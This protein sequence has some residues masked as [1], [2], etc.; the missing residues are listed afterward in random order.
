MSFLF[1]L[2]R[3]LKKTMFGI[4]LLALAIQMPVFSDNYDENEEKQPFPRGYRGI[5]LRMGLNDVRQRLLNDPWFDYRGESELSMR[6]RPN[7]SFIDAGG[8]LFISRGLFQFEATEIEEEAV[9]NPDDQNDTL[10]LSPVSSIQYQLS[11]IVLELNPRTIDWYTVY[12]TL[13]KRYGEPR[14]LNPQRVWWQDARVRLV[15]E[16]PL[17]VKYLD[18]SIFR[19]QSSTQSSPIA[20]RAAARSDFLKEF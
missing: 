2:C 4:L 18:Q 14:E 9:Y 19:P 15:L 20:A 8:S 3:L 7:S 11:A 12:T 13:E 17:T 1:Y 10:E 5:E 6:E 16:R